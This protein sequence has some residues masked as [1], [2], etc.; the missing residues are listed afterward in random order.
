MSYFVR[1]A[2]M[3]KRILPYKRAKFRKLTEI[4]NFRCPLRWN[5]IYSFQ[6][7]VLQMQ[8]FA[9]LLSAYKCQQEYVYNY[10]CTK[11]ESMK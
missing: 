8:T 3:L 6:L 10:L 5:V 1:F 2:S 11:Q 7:S 4:R 9:I